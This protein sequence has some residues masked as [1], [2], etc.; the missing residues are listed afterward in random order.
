MESTKRYRQFRWIDVANPSV[1]EIALVA[2]S[3]QLDMHQANDCIEPGHLHKIEKQDAYTFVILRAH[4]TTH[5]AD[6]ITITGLSNKITFFIFP[7]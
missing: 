3:H 7:D 4:A 1:A 2:Q 5:H 6:D